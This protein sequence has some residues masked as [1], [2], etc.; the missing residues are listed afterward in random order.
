[1]TLPPTQPFCRIWKARSSRHPNRWYREK[2]RRKNESIQ[3]EIYNII[4]QNYQSRCTNWRQVA[5]FTRGQFWPSGIVV[6][7]VFVSV[8]LCVN[9]L[10]VRAITQDPCKL[11]SPNL[12]QRC[13]IP[14]LSS[15][16]FFF[17]QSTLTFKVKFNSK[18][19]M[20]PILSLSAP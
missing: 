10:L 14:W 20:C 7:C 2:Q 11:L 3:T 17:G 12:D 9:H 6:A 19:K 15:L 4:H 8:S 1:M 16:L 5:I 13:K 18:V